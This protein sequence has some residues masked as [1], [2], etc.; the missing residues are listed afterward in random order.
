MMI[1][2]SSSWGGGGGGT[3]ADPV[4]MRVGGSKQDQIRSGQVRSGKLDQ[5]PLGGWVDEWKGV[6][7]WMNGHRACSQSVVMRAH[8]GNAPL[9]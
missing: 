5:R 4:S 2:I 8:A 7:G 6:C 3:L 1:I 9:R